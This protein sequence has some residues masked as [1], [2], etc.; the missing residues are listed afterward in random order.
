MWKELRPKPRLLPPGIM[1]VGV[2]GRFRFGAETI[3]LWGL[4][5]FCSVK[6]WQDD[7]TPS[8]IGFQLFEDKKGGDIPLVKDDSTMEFSARWLVRAVNIQPGRYHANRENSFITVDFSHRLTQ[9]QLD[10]FAKRR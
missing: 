2:K 8:L 10:T 4:S 7:K 3:R 6:I 5:K 1:T 9:K